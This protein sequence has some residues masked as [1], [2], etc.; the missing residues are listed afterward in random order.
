MFRVIFFLLQDMEAAV[1][2]QLNECQRATDLQEKCD[3]MEQ[4]NDEVS[5]HFNRW[6]FNAVLTLCIIMDS[7]FRFDAINLG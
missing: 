6:K 2:A 5:F 7:P 3:F 4:C 1:A